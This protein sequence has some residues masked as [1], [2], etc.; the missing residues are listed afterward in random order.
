MALII[1]ISCIMFAKR[2]EMKN[3]FDSEFYSYYKS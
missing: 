2:S 3:D 1:L